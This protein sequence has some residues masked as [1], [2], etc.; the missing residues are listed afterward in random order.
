[1]TAIF[2][3]ALVRH[4]PPDIRAVDGIDLDI[5]EGQIFAFLGANGSG[6]TT[7][8]RMLTTLIQPTSGRACVQGLDVVKDGRR[9]REQ[10][11][12]ALQE[13]SLSMTC[14]RGASC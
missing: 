10:I 6:K 13:A 8:V 1:M 11:G 9:V 5:P 7:T 12:V 3:E 2:A 14:R 4:F